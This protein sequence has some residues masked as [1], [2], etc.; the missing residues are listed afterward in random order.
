MLEWNYKGRPSKMNE[1]NRQIVAVFDLK[2]PNT[3]AEAADRIEQIT[4]LRRSQTQVREYLRRIHFRRIKTGTALG[5][6]DPAR[7]EEFKKNPRPF[8]RRG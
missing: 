2:P 5:K 4:G 7:Q 3:L 8:A 6:I 1:F